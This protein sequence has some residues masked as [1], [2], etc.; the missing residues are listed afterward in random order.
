[1]QGSDDLSDIGKFGGNFEIENPVPRPSS[2]DVDLLNNKLHAMSLKSRMTLHPGADSMRII[3]LENEV[4]QLREQHLNLKNDYSMVEE[5]FRK[6]EVL[7]HKLTERYRKELM[8]RDEELRKVHNEMV[9]LKGQI[10]VAVRVRKYE[11]EKNEDICVV[12][13]NDIKFDNKAEYHFEHIFNARNDQ[14]MVFGQVKEL[15]LSV[16][17]GYNVCLIAYGP[18]GSGKTFTMRGENNENLAGVI[19]RSIQ[20]LLEHSEQQ[21]AAIGWKFNFS[22]SYL[23]VY[24]EEVFDL[25]DQRKKCDLKLNGSTSSTNVIGLKKVQIKSI[26]DTE[27]LMNLADSYRSTASTGCNSQS[28][29]SHAIFQIHVDAIHSKTGQI[30]KCSLNLVDL[31]GSER[32]KESGAQGERFAELTNINQSLSTLKRCI[33][34]QMNNSSHIPFR[35]SKLT[36]LLRTYLGKGSSKTMFIAHLNPNDVAETKR[37]LEFTKELRSTN[38]GR[39]QV[40]K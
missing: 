14:E 6:Q 32:V 21:L 25:L 23:E 35:E 26:F 18:T 4:R 1:M 24:N 31:A 22:A 27:T 36:L 9:D 29:R 33:R 17:H 28:S 30:A 39:A 19:P 16:L 20:F 3:Q 7:L 34:A 37:T 38:L 11:D 8:E 5:K 40:Q 12:G 2:N 13:E 15:I 10:R